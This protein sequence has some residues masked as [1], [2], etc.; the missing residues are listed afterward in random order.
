ML[1]NLIQG[2]KKPNNCQMYCEIFVKCILKK[3]KKI[4]FFKILHKNQQSFFF[5]LCLKQQK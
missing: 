2:F 3:E 5:P 4:N 1:R